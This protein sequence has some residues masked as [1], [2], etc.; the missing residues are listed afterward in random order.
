[1]TRVPFSLAIDATCLNGGVAGTQVATMQTLLSLRR[2]H[3]MPIHVFLPLNAGSD[4]VRELE[5]WPEFK[6]ARVLGDDA[7][8]TAD[9]VH[10][11]YQAFWA[12]DLALIKRLG[13]RIAITQQDLIAWDNPTYFPSRRRWVHHRAI[14]RAALEVADAIVCPSDYVR[15]TLVSTGLAD[16]SRCFTVWQGVDHARTAPS[17]SRPR[18][19]EALGNDETILCVGADYAHKNR[20]FAMAV[21][22]DLQRRHGWTGRLVFA[23]P[24]MRH[25]SSIPEEDAFLR[26]HPDC[27]DAVLRLQG[28]TE[29]EK[30]WLYDRARLVIYP[31]RSE[32][33]GFIPF[34]STALGVPVLFASV[35]SLAELLPRELAYIVAWDVSSTADSAVRLLRDEGVRKSQ[36][37]AIQDAAKRYTWELT[38][39]TLSNIYSQLA[40]L[41]SSGGQRGLGVRLDTLR[42]RLGG[43][44]LSQAVV[45]I[46]MPDPRRA[47]TVNARL[48]AALVRFAARTALRLNQV[49]RRAH[50]R[51]S[52]RAGT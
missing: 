28:V 7:L 8:G 46:G 37:E 30:A 50:E 29:G 38:A 34:E 15:N 10:R 47:H 26:Q 32:G 23:G 35:S 4:A 24:H 49:R 1:M 11:P 17:P 45:A 43:L 14:T 48:G 22:S 25:G 51:V 44:H 20:V 42:P 31:T 2:N 16:A 36:V 18:G 9:V 40:Q 41:P 13:R 33:F 52:A 12:F 6:L 39:R 21:L 19:A 3:V 5:K 27:A